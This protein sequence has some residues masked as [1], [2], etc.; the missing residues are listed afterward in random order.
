MKEAAF[1]IHM[2]FDEKSSG[3]PEDMLHGTFEQ[4]KI[5]ILSY[6]HLSITTKVW[7]L[8]NYFLE[9]VHEYQ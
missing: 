1:Y 8:W 6:H 3:K 4:I 7:V 2:S 5:L 9:M